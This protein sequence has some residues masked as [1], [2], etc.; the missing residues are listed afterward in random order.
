MDY[1]VDSNECGTD[2]NDVGY[3]WLGGFLALAVY[4]PNLVVHW[5]KC[6]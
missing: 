1:L 5:Q 6:L 3:Q 4:L 2:E